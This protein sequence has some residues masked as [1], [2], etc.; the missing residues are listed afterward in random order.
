VH[1]PCVV[2]CVTLSTTWFFIDKNI[3][4]TQQVPRELYQ[5]GLSQESWLRWAHKLELVQ[6]KVPSFWCDLACFMGTCGF[7]ICTC[8]GN[9]TR[10]A[11]WSALKEWQDTFNNQVLVGLGMF[12]KTQSNTVTVY[13]G[14][15][16]DGSPRSRDETTSWI[17]FAMTPQESTKLKIEPHN[18]GEVG[19]FIWAQEEIDSPMAVY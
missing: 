3:A 2:A 10:R 16:P 19:C 11:Y 17:A 15:N 7:S 1:R 5:R 4:P 8:R 13:I 14:R 12:C 18:Y 6:K 9:W